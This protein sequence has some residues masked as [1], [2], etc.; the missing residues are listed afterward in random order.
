[1]EDLH[2]QRALERAGWT[3]WRCW[4]S[5]FVRDPEACMLHLFRTLSNMGIEPVGAADIDLSE[6]VEYR[7]IADDAPVAQSDNEAA[8][9][10][11]VREAIEDDLGQ[12]R[13]GT[14]SAGALAGEIATSTASDVSS[15]TTRHREQSIDSASQET[16]LHVEVGDSVPL[17]LC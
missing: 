3:S 6:V 2:R 12:H 7:E 16:S 13:N 8:R 15:P 17:L 9:N 14:R 1:M 5:S 4:G 10:S 11:S